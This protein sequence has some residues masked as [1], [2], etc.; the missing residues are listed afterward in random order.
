MRDHHRCKAGPVWNT[1]TPDHHCTLSF[2]SNQNLIE[3]NSEKEK[4]NKGAP[5]NHHI[6]SGFER[7]EQV[8][9]FM[10]IRW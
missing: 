2:S 3:L 9:D 5:V 4:A 1:D 6:S 10:S 7:G 8:N